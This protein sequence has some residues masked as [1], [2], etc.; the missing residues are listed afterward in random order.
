MAGLAKNPLAG[1]AAL[2]LAGAIPTNTGGLN[3]TGISN[4]TIS[5]LHA[6]CFYPKNILLSFLSRSFLWSYSESF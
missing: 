1:L 3:S 4:S 5:Q 2:G 6:E